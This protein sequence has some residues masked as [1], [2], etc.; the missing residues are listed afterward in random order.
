ML[1]LVAPGLAAFVEAPDPLQA[2]F[3]VQPIELPAQLEVEVRRGRRAERLGDRE[4]H[5]AQAVEY[6]VVLA[7]QPLEGPL[8]V[9]DP[10]LEDDADN[11][12]PLVDEEVVEVVDLAFELAR[13]PRGDVGQRAG[14]VRLQ[15]SLLEALVLPVGL[16]RAEDRVEVEA[17]VVDDDEGRLGHLPRLVRADPEPADGQV[18]GA[19]APDLLVEDLEVERVEPAVRVARG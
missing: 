13:H 19:P 7:E 16:D 18:A 15:E 14:L 6:V 5:L 9:L 4:V 1:G 3:G 8:V 10:V 17:A 12:P 2:A 11:P